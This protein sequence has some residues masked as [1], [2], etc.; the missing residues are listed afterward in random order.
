MSSA[1]HIGA[2]VLY[3][4]ASLRKWIPA[5]VLSIAAHDGD[6][7]L[8]IGK[9]PEVAALDVKHGPGPHQWLH[10]REAAAMPDLPLATTMLCAAMNTDV[11]AGAR[12]DAD[13]LYPLDGTDP[14]AVLALREA[15]IK[16]AS[17]A[18]WR[19]VRAIWTLLGVDS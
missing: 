4:S 7:M 15:H 18:R 16:G 19:I 14:N 11:L 5:V 10:Y 9:G 13:A 3:H 8:D 17:L 1:T 6:L 12:A 2:E